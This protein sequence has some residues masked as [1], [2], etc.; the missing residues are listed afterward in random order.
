MFRSAVTEELYLGTLSNVERKLYSQESA[1]ITLKKGQIVFSENG[2]PGGFYSLLKGKV[3]L[4]KTGIYGKKQIFQICKEGDVFGFHPVLNKSRYPDSAQV[5]EEAEL[6]VTP[7]AVLERLLDSNHA[8]CRALLR[9]ISSEFSRLIAQETMLA[10]KSVAER[11]A[12]VLY[13]LS[14][15][16]EKPNAETIIPLSRN[17]LADLCGTVKETLVR[18]LHGLKEDKILDVVGT[19]AH[20]RILKPS[21]LKKRGSVIDSEML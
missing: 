18:E 16:Y 7:N 1:T 19:R 5:L 2:I 8:F 6:R 13:H 12:T 9:A 17:E 4:Y 3:M 20:L 21:A 11:I 14:S 10:Q 15:I